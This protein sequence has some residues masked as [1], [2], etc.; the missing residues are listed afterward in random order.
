MADIVIHQGAIYSRKGWI[1]PGYL[2]ITNQQI[3]KISA[4]E[5]PGD[6][7]GSVSQV[8]SAEN[9]AVIPGLTNAHTHLS[10]V[11]MRGLA[12]GR[13]LL[14]WLK[15]VIWPLQ[16]GLTPEDME[17]AAMLGLVE[18]LRCGATNVVDHHKITRTPAHTDSVC[19]AVEK[20]GLRFRLARSWS[21]KGS[22]AENPKDILFDLARLLEKWKGH[23]HIQ[24][25]NGPLALWRCSE[26][27]LRQSHELVR[28]NGRKTHFHVSETSDEVTM[29]LEEYQLRPVEWLADLG[30]LDQNTEV[31]HAVWVDEN[32]ISLIER[33]HSAVVHCPVSNA[34]LG[35]G[36]APISSFLDRKI[37][38]RLG[39][40][41]PASNDTQD[42]WETTKAAVSLARIQNLDPT[43]LPPDQALEI[44]LANRILEKG[45]EADIV[46]VD[47]DHVR[48]SPVQDLS[49]A[50][51][52]G[53]HGSDVDTVI[54]AGRILMKDKKVLVVNEEDLLKKCRNAVAQL[55]IRSG[56]DQ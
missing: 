23:S 7:L 43:L 17:L 13:A 10:Q 6:L 21:D 51:V 39:T 2:E 18:N 33:S 26:D 47:L 36:V 34:V 1:N 5:A 28:K 24:I 15:E 16:A 4:G 9:Q 41:G 45:S 14:P 30:V 12:G 42:I 32:E 22:G 20:M 56:L 54:V 48:V 50:L 46:I 8:I 38:L 37:K 55:R 19:S 40:D 29:S 3:S 44:A 52:L 31:V 53:T 35:S 49:S 25:D 11:F 27:T